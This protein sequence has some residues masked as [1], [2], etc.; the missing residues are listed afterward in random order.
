MSDFGSDP[1][2]TQFHLNIV[3]NGRPRTASAKCRSELITRHRVGVKTDN[4]ISDFRI[5]M[6]LKPFAGL[7]FTRNRAGGPVSR[8]YDVTIA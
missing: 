3:F 6:E 5:K 8:P 2:Q 4:L 7:I 1:C